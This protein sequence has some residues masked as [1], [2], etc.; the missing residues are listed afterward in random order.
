MGSGGGPRG[1]PAGLGLW[2]MPGEVWSYFWLVSFFWLQNNMD[3]QENTLCG[4]HAIEYKLAGK[5][6]LSPLLFCHMC[7]EPAARPVLKLTTSMY[8][9]ILLSSRMFSRPPDVPRSTVTG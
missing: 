1:E 4:K 8:V 7:C 9:C 2:E 6:P 5:L 3:S